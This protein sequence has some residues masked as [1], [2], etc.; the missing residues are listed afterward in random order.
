MDRHV[1]IVKT[2]RL[3]DQGQFTISGLPPHQRYLAV[4]VDYIEPGDPQSAEFLQRAKAVASVGFGLSTGDQ[5]NIEVP[6]LIRWMCAI[7]L[8]VLIGAVE[9]AAG[10]QPARPARPAAKPSDQ[11]AAVITGK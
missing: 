5:K 9:V 7:A 8:A 4:A 2:A 1:A 10:Q 6:L 11:W 3:T